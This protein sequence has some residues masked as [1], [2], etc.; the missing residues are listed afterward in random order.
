M[1]PFCKIIYNGKATDSPV[2]TD[3]GKTP[4]WN[5][6]MK[7]EV[8]DEMAP[9]LFM[10]YNKNPLLDDDLICQTQ[11]LKIKNLIGAN[12]CLTQNFQTYYENKDAGTIQIKT[13]FTPH[14]KPQG[15]KSILEFTMMNIELAEALKPKASPGLDIS[16]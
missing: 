1:D 13:Q 16:I 12:N 14:V 6:R 11:D 10:I 9:I 15:D 5:F 2:K 4:K 7:I 8:H 3:A